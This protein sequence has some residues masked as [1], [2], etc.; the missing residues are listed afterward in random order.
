MNVGNRESTARERRAGILSITMEGP[1]VATPRIKIERQTE[2][3]VYVKSSTRL[4]EAIVI[5][6]FDDMAK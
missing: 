4:L 6:M 3:K 5:E 2:R 1:S